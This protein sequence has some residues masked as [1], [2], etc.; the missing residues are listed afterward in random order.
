MVIA[1]IGLGELLWTLLVL[2]VMVHVLIAMFIV[3]G[4]VLRSRD[5]SGVAKAGWLLAMLVVPI[6][7]LVIYLV[8]RG[9]GIGERTLER[10]R[11]PMAPPPPAVAV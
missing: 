10:Q 7:A 1:E 11:R 8:A 9:D 5:L 3:I 4:D 2:F 6:V